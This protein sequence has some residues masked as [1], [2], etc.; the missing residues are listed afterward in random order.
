MKTKYYTFRQNNSGGS[1]DIEHD[2]GI[3]IAVIIEAETADQANNRA[4][5]IG[6][7]FDGCDKGMDCEC[8]GDRWYRADEYDGKNEPE[9]Y[10]TK[11]IE[12][13]EYKIRNPDNTKRGWHVDRGYVH[14]LDGTIKAMETIE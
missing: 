9:I 13:P 4:E 14:M 2:R 5:S 6:L 12:I 7:Y 1:F 11:L 8:C 3:S 10:G